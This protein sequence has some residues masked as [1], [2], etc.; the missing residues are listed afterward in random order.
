[1]STPQISLFVLAG[2]LAALGL[3][4]WRA[5]PHAPVNLWFG[6]QTL[7]LACWV[8]GVAGLQGSE[9]LHAWG[10]FAFSSA[11]LIPPAFLFFTR[12]FPAATAWPPRT[13]ALIILA[14]GVVLALVAL[15]TPLVVADVFVGPRGLERRTGS[16]YPIYALYLLLTWGVACVVF[17]GKWRHSRGLPRA[18]LQYVGAGVIIAA[19][20]GIGINLLLPWITASSMYSWLGPYFTLP[21]A[22]LVAHAIIRHRL[23]DLRFVI[24]RGIAYALVATVA[25]VLLIVSTRTFFL[26]HRPD[27]PN[28]DLFLVIIAGLLMLTSPAQHFIQRFIDPY[29]YRGRLDHASALRNAMRQLARLMEPKAFARQLR[30]IFADTLVP[31]SFTL[32]VPTSNQTFECLQS[33][34][35]QE[36]LTL[37][38]DELR[39]VVS[40]ASLGA[41]TVISP[42][43]P[44]RTPGTRV[45]AEFGIDILIVL[46]RR[47]EV[48]GVAL[49]GPRRSGEPY[50]AKDLE[51]IEAVS[52]L[53]AVAL[54]NTLLYRQRIHMLEYSERLLESLESSVVA[55]DVSGRITS[56]NPAASELFGLAKTKP[57]P[58]LDALPSEIGWALGLAVSG[59]FVARETELRVDHPLR[60]EV[61]VILS[62]AVLRSDDRTTAGALAVVTDLSTVKELEQNQRRLEH[63]S[64]MARFYAGIAHEIR[65]PLAA[66]SNF[67]AML[68][69]RFDDPEYRDTASRL[70]PMEVSRITALADRL[71]LMAPGAGGKLAPVHLRPL[72]VDIIAI[73]API[74]QDS[75]IQVTLNCDD[76]LPAVNADPNQLIQLFVNLLRNAMEA[77]PHGGPIILEVHTTPTT[78][79][80]G[81]IVVRI[82]DSGIGIDPSIRAS[83]FE[84]FFTTKPTGT[85]LGLAICREIAAFH[86][87]TLSI[88]PRAGAKGTIAEVSLPYR[89]NSYVAGGVELAAAIGRTDA[90]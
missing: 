56:H 21:F 59:L 20:G 40:R 84:P 9:H 78:G 27:L 73:H 65:N 39:A 11:V 83:I 6:V 34:H 24:H 89:I 90:P 25:C 4:V 28:V 36:R 7:L 33:D 53:A 3:S 30:D 12:V 62:T 63:L 8:L 16:L 61:P 51:F 29:L 49:L 2:A 44:T 47:G 86:G 80:G 60:G 1:M 15:L 35:P 32:L 71:R 58:D 82:V 19:V 67:V 14:A 87:A 22:V 50:Y 31:D 66:I 75:K 13:P 10:R 69:D 76:P 5:R 42:D 18:Q 77:M 43:N 48:L 38:S 17:A 72:F 68:P 79:R 70:L 45:L 57:E 46:R 55:I 64:L 52:E 26:R 81:S 23:M 88:T 37:I 41:V 85:G 54:E 74:A